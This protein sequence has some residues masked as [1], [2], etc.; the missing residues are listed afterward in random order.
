MHVTSRTPWPPLPLDDWRPT[1]ETLHL[2]MQIVGKVCLALTARNNHFWNIAFKVTARGI[3]TP[4]LVAGDVRLGIRFDFLAHQLVIETADGRTESIRLEPKT[5]AA[6]YAEVTA[7]LARLGVQPP[8]WPV[9]V[10]LPT[11]VRLDRDDQHASYDPAAAQRCWH[12][13]LAIQPVLENFRA[14]FIGKCSPVHFFWGS[15]DLAVTR[16]NGRRAPARP[17]ADAVTRE[18][19]SHEVIS[20]GFWPGSGPVQEPAFY[21]YCAPEPAGFKTASV[22]PAAAHYSQELSE[23]LLPYEAV[24]TAASPETALRAFLQSTYDAA[25]DLARWDRVELER[26]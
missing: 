24:R 3:D 21:A 22:Q 14:Q 4:P 7:A 5:V 1:Y 16:F 6:F 11:P 18:S 23:Y 13:L 26:G 2:W 17:E 15:F 10:E 20:H 25:A 12:V 8:I 19:Y 9:A